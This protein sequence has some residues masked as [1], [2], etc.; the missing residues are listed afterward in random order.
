MNIDRRGTFRRG[1][2]FLG[3]A[4]FAV[5]VG[6]AP[7]RAADD[8]WQI[9][10]I[11]ATSGPLK[12]AGDSTEISIRIAT[13]EINAS[14]GINGKKIK[15]IQYDTAD[16][17]RQA[18]VAVR[19]LAEDDKVLAIIGPLSSG[20]TAVAASDAER[21]GVLILPYSS[22]APGLTDGKTFTWRLAATEDQQFA[23][24]LT[25]PERQERAD[26]N[27]RH[28]V[29]VR[30]PQSPISPAR[31]SIQRSSNRPEFRST[32]HSV[33]SS[34]AS[35]SPPRWR[36]WSSKTQ[37][38]S[39]WRRITIRR[40]RWFASCIVQNYKG[41]VLGSQLFA[42]PN[43]MDIF[44]KDADG[45][46]FVASFWHDLNDQTKDFTNKFVAAAAAKGIKKHWPHH[47]DAASYDTVFL[48]KQLIEKSGVTGDPSKLKQE[49]I[50]RA[51]RPQ[52][53]YIFRCLGQRHLLQG[54]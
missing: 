37:T 26:Q 3:A 19:T 17:P 45:T 13:S 38:R 10:F 22:S 8:E 20:E 25:A 36:K 34:T 31:R 51:R 35:T 53:R 9:G 7:T 11:S 50:A 28:H 30:R 21:I 27:G 40:L 41:R 39:L 49:R 33:C 44:G 52:G 1:A 29:C 16:D 15:L 14:G 24:L 2:L 18:S 4:L 43:L 23:R 12:Q 32:N 47:V 46:F 54:Q 42:D 48:L 5:S 6:A